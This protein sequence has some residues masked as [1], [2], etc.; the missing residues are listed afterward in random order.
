MRE[1]YNEDLKKLND[2]LVEMG[3]LVE[4][5]LEK[6]KKAFKEQDKTLA[7]DIVRGDQSINNLEHDIE[8]LCFKLMLRQQP[9]ATDLRV[10]ATALKVVTDL[11][12]IGDQ[13]ADISEM[14]LSFNGKY[15]YKTVEHIPTMMKVCREMVHE[16]IR[17]YVTKD[18][19]R[20]KRADAMDDQVDVLFSEV[21]A[22]I[23]EILKEGKENIDDCL[24]YLIIAK[25]LE[26][27][28]D[29]AINILTRTKTSIN[30]ELTYS[31]SSL[32]EFKEIYEN[33]IVLFDQSIQSFNQEKPFE[34]Y[35][36]GLL[37]LRNFIRDLNNKALDD[38]IVRLRAHKC[39]TASGIVFT[40][41]LQDL[42]RTGDHSYNISKAGTNDA[43]L[44]SQM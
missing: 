21:K 3:N 6:S 18:L 26:R 35:Q 19:E 17:A 34:E 38:H 31:S 16:A 40:K 20:G 44:I 12:R 8:A 22:E 23:V 28:G 39:H 27:I 13:A 2:M 37:N 9:V 29:H 14:S 24:N 1:Q 43:A 15:P 30:D 32:D 4:I 5:S 11:E 10:I 7:E 33:V 36:T 25:Y 41:I 42:E